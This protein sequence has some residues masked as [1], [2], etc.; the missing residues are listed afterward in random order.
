MRSLNEDAGAVTGLGVAA[1]S[2]PVGEIDQNFNPLQDDVVRLAAVD[3][4]HKTQTTGVVFM[5]GMIE[6]LWGG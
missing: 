3:I 5:T 2:P 1:A 4:G 6:P